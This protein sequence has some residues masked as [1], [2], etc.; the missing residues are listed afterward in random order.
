MCR[1]PD[2][3]HLRYA[4]KWYLEAIAKDLRP[5]CTAA[6]AEAAMK[7]RYLVTRSLDPKG[8]GQAGWVTRWKPALNAFAITFAD[9]MSAAEN[10]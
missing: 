4:S 5:I 3:R 8:L 6:T 10:L 2:P 7:T 9:R 1:A